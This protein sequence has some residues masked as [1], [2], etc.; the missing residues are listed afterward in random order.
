M[1]APIAIF[2]YKR[3][4]ETKK[5]IEAIKANYLASESE[6]FIFSDNA[7]NEAEQLKVDLVRN[8]IRQI[9]GFKKITI[10]ENEINKGLA[11]SIISGVTLILESYT[12][13]IILEDD[14]VVTPN[15]LDFMNASLKFYENEKNIYSVNG[16]SLKLPIN[17]ETE[18]IYF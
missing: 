3:I 2:V 5:T 16:F 12:N 14:L 11:K 7:K 6:L 18:K 15:F 17:K 10:Y 4:D 8:F 1:I 13:V 9:T